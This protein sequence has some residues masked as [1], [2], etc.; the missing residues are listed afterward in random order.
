MS[1]IFYL[2]DRVAIG[3]YIIIAAMVVWQMRKFLLAQTEYRSTYF[4]LERDLARVQQGGALTSAIIA[5]QFAV[6]VLGVQ[7]VIVPFLQ[8]EEDLQVQ[9]ASMPSDGDFLTATPA[10][11]DDENFDIAPVELPED[12]DSGI[13]LLTPTLTPTPVGTIIPNAP[14]IEGCDSEQALLQVPA[15]GMRVFQPILVIG[16]AYSDNF[17]GA[18]IEI[19]GPSTNNQYSVV[20]NIDSPVRSMEAFFQFNP[21][22]YMQGQY[23]FRVVVFDSANEITAAC[24]VTIYISPALSTSTPT[25]LPQGGNA[26]VIEVTATPSS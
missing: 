15:N 22:R 3:I 20:S 8:T 17:S 6:V 5:L 1:G 11:I 16:Q 19:S 9:L 10:P 23:D 7:Q 18:K 26:P 12:E 2:I 4:E 14:P 13:I 25:P 21:D 24:K